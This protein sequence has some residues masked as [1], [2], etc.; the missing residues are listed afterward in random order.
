MMHGQ[1]N[2]KYSIGSDALIAN[3][4][5]FHKMYEYVKNQWHR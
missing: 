2:I 3:H 5:P 4:V 1:Q